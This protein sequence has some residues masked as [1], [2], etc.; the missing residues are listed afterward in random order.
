MG[1]RNGAN[2]IHGL[3]RKR[4]EVAGQLK[5]AQKAMETVKDDLAAID[6]AL[7]ICGY[8]GNPNGIAPRTKYRQL[9]GRNELKL[10]IRKHLNQTPADDETLTKTIIE[11]KGWDKD[12]VWSDVLKRVRDCLQ[13]EQKVG[14][15]VQDFG[16]DGVL[17]KRAT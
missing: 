5:V 3:V 2:L 4:S 1:T 17:W 15:V 8:K 12:A 10:T 16:P 7:E 13:R 9:F 11:A 6:R 14:R